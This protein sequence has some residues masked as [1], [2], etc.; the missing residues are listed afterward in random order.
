MKLHAADTLNAGVHQIQSQRPYS[1]PELT[2]VHQ[3]SGFNA[4]ILA[5]F[6][7]TVGLGFARGALLDVLRIAE[8]AVDASRP[9]LFDKPCFCCGVVRE[10]SGELK[11]GSP[12]AVSLAGGIVFHIPIYHLTQ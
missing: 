12:F 6:P 11:E 1:Q 5:A 3:G 4:E 9:A 7:A 2:I 8:G 10:E